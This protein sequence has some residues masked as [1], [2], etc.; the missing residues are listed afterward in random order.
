MSR[1]VRVGAFLVIGTALAGFLLWGLAGLP[2]FGHYQGEYGK[3]LSSVT[4]TQRHASNVVGAVV[5]DYRG[6]DTLG[7]EFILFTSVMGVAFILRGKL[8]IKE[9]APLDPVSNDAVRVFG[10][11]M[12]PVV[13]L[14][15]LWL[16]AYGYV[17]PGGGFQGGVA[18]GC[19]GALLWTSTSYRRYQ[20]LTPS[21]VLDAVEGFGAGAY[22]VIGVIGLGLDGA[23]LANFLPLGTSGTLASAGSI[24]LLNWASALEVAGANIL[25]YR[26]FFQ[27]YV[28][29]FPGV[30][31]D[32]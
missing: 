18:V 11:L 29:T 15:G 9:Q 28:Q 4:Q 17:T 21:S 12:V 1:S 8:S 31:E 27:E 20:K 24:G 5:F 16:A 7:E 32:D 22:V 13:L 25:L 3:L 19:A 23:F 6:F 14:A 10:P 2:A 30:E 26:E